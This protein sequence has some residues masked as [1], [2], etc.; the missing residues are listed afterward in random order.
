[1]ED[2]AGSRGPATAVGRRRPA[3]AAG[4]RMPAAAAGRGCGWPAAQ[5]DIWTRGRGDEGERT[6]G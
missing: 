5:V 2:D 6:I 1:M 4:R 3:A